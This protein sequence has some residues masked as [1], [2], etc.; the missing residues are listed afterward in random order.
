[1]P[2]L[3]RAKEWL[4][5]AAIVGVVLTAPTGT[6]NIVMPMIMQTARRTPNK[7]LG[8]LFIIASF[9]SQKVFIIP[10]GID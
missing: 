1:V 4:L 3:F 9:L 8:V 2:S 10:F 6:M 7:R 5:P